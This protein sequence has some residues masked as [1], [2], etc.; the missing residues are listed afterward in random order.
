MDSVSDP[1][2]LNSVGHVFD[3]FCFAEDKEM[4]EGIVLLTESEPLPFMAVN[5]QSV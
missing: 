3:L 1:G 2:S 5:I 4:G